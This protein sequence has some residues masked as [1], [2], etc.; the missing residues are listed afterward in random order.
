[1]SAVHQTSVTK[2]VSPIRDAFSLNDAVRD[3][4][5]TPQIDP[6]ELLSNAFRRMKDARISAAPVVAGERVVG[7]ITHQ[8]ATDTLLR[9]QR[10]STLA[11]AECMNEAPLFMDVADDVEKAADALRHH[12]A[13][14]VG[15][16]MLFQGIVTG[17]EISHF[18]RSVAAPFLL[19]QEIEVT[20]RHLAALCVPFPRAL[21][22]LREAGHPLDRRMTTFEDL[23]IGDFGRLVRR[24][25]WAYFED[26][27]GAD[28]DRFNGNYSPVPGIRNRT[29]H[30]RRPKPSDL[31]TLQTCRRWLRGRL[32]KALWLLNRASAENP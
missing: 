26:G 11:A 16:P 2:D 14:L 9:S 32:A 1:M 25:T 28:Y 5:N 22:L 21:E 18:Y 6:D 24:E 4:A 30:F 12:E 23:A 3:R 19:I 20:L 17:V 27:F 15:S 31:E 13:I 29:F 8:V 10:R 7:V